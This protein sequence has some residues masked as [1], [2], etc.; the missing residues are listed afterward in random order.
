M[1]ACDSKKS[2]QE[3]STDVVVGFI[4]DP[5]TG[6]YYT[7]YGDKSR[8]I[9][10]VTPERVPKDADIVFARLDHLF[11]YEGVHR[12]VVMSHL[13]ARKYGC[14]PLTT[15]PPDADRHAFVVAQTGERF[16][17]LRS[18]KLVIYTKDGLYQ[19][20]LRPITSISLLPWTLFSQVRDGP[21]MWYN[22]DDLPPGAWP[23]SI[24]AP[25]PGDGYG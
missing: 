23:I 22:A 13:A 11:G 4:H 9:L 5:H 19:R 6:R 10:E 17:L 24:R 8:P 25:N 1:G 12:D 21:S 15:P 2:C 16:Q 14:A 20:Q 3:E 18:G 7:V